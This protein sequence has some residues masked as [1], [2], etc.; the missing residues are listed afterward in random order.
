[1]DRGTLAGGPRSAR[2]RG[3]TVTWQDR[4]PGFSR[5][6]SQTQSGQ[7]SRGEG[8]PELVLCCSRLVRPYR[9]AVDHLH[10]PPYGHM[11]ADTSR[12]RPAPSVFRRYH[13]RSAHTVVRGGRRARDRPVTAGF[14]S[15]GVCLGT[16]TRSALGRIS[17]TIGRSSSTASPSMPA[18]SCDTVPRTVMR[19]PVQVITLSPG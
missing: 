13:S 7:L 2:Y 8:C 12:R 15:G 4:H 5:T 9:R 17:H 11:G 19:V 10:G 1:M 3:G 18:G 14:A 16:N 6:G